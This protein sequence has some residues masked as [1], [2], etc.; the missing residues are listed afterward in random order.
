MLHD[1]HS[2]GDILL[3]SARRE[4]HSREKQQRG[5]TL[6]RKEFRVY[7]LIAPYLINISIIFTIVPRLSW[8]HVKK[9]VFALNLFSYWNVPLISRKLYNTRSHNIYV[10][11]SHLFWSRWSW[12]NET[13][14]SSFREESAAS[15]HQYARLNSK[16]DIWN[17][18][19]DYKVHSGD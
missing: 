18:S 4:R 12:W 6:T 14:W 3:M 9:I 10:R 13:S 17:I 7:I 5:D 1:R 16:R 15:Y 2:I 19:Y 11:M 8:I